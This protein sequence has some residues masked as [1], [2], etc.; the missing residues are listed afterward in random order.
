MPN[1][2]TP[3]GKLM[4]YPIIKKRTFEP[5]VPRVLPDFAPVTVEPWLVAHRELRTSRRI[6]RIFD[7]LATEL[8]RSLSR[9]KLTVWTVIQW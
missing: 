2:A 9:G 6:R 1:S 4:F 5:A 7:F 8:S 3:I